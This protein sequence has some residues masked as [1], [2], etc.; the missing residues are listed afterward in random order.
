MYQILVRVIVLA[1]LVE[2]GMTAEGFKNCRSRQCLER[3]QKAAVRYSK[4]DWKV[5]SVFPGEAER[6]RTEVRK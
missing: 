5:I 6:F 4:V 1:A 3:V 2:L